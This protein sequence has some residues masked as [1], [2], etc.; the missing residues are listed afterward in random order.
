MLIA[1]RDLFRLLPLSLISLASGQDKPPLVSGAFPF[2]DLPVRRQGGAEFRDLL[3][4]KTPTGESLEVHETVLPPG[5]SPH[6][7]HRHQHSEMFLLREGAVEVTINGKNYRLASPGSA[8]FVASND[9]H[10]IR[11]AGNTPAQYFVVA[12]GPMG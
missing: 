12:V 7:P 11:N 10:G 8:A 4:G 3:R 1:R 9:E 6:P 5:G 2:Q